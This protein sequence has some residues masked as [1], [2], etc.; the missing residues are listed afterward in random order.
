[1][2]SF[3]DLKN[4]SGRDSKNVRDF[5]SSDICVSLGLSQ[6]S[7]PYKFWKWYLP[8]VPPSCA[9]SD[10]R[11][12]SHWSADLSVAGYTII[13]LQI[14]PFWVF[15]TILHH[16]YTLYTPP[17]PARDLVSSFSQT[18]IW[19]PYVTGMLCHTPGTELHHLAPLWNQV[20]AVRLPDCSLDSDAV[21]R[22]RAEEPVAPHRH[23]EGDRLG[24]QLGRHV[25]EDTE[26]RNWRQGQDA[27]PTG[28]C[29]FN[30]HFKTNMK[31]IV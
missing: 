20:V 4:A 13:I 25:L 29:V 2:S 8:Y 11:E 19:S 28:R 24:H 5:A 7:Y 3:W 27:R 17:P 15:G 14:R 23:G 12:N 22:P 21:Q 18:Q 10:C 30:L 31:A 9:S 16:C 1:M 6:T 26:E